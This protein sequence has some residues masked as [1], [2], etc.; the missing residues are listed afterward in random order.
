VADEILIRHYTGDDRAGVRDLLLRTFGESRGFDHFESGNPAGA[1]IRV[2]AKIG[3]RVVGFNSWNPWLIPSSREPLLVYQSGASAVGEE[4]RGRGVFAKLLA[5]GEATAKE[6]GVRYFIGFPNPASLGSFLRAGWEL[7]G[8]LNLRLLATLPVGT[9][10]EKSS[11][12]IRGSGIFIDFLRWRYGAGGVNVLRGRATGGKEY[13]IIY[14]SRKKNGIH[15]NT[16][17]D[18]IGENG[19]RDFSVLTNGRML[20][21]PAPGLVFTR[22]NENMA[23]CLPWTCR[24][25]RSWETPII[26]RSVS[27]DP[28]L[29]ENI[30]KASICYG[31]IDAA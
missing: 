27:S 4:T 17:M 31:D 1:P 21:L 11:S 23:G 14:R 16:I 22:I 6:R 10:M 30:R 9:G 24:V 18:V 15:L 3:G 8:H 28:I 12:T 26:I 29:E 19:E 25:P 2:V 7:I 13:S 5:I 20:R